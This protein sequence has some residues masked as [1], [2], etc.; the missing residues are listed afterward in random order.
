MNS[1]TSQ[2]IPVIRAARALESLRDSG[3][4]L[5][6]ALGEPTDNSIEAGAN[7]VHIRLDEG[8]NPRGK[9]H[10][11]RIAVADDGRGMN[12]DLLQHYLVL[13]FSTR[14]MR[15]DTIGKYG[16]GAKL[17][18]LNFACR[19][20]V[21]SRDRVTAPWLHVYFDLNKAIEEEK[22]GQEAKI[23]PP[24]QEPVPDDLRDLRPEGT[25]TLVVWSEM[26][27]LEE[28]RMAPT[29]EELRYEVE[30]EMSR[31]FRVFISGGIAIKVNGKALLAHDPLFLM[32]NTWA[33][34]VLQ[35]ELG[36]SGTKS[37]EDHFAAAIIANKETISIG[38]SIA[39]VTVTVYPPEVLRKRGLGG[40]ELVKKLRVPENQGCLS[41]MRLD[42]EVS[43]T[44]VPR[45]FPTAVDDPDRFI[46]IEVAFKPELDAYFGV[47]N[48]K[49]GVEP[50]GE[51][52]DK[53]RNL[54]SKHIKSARSMIQ[55]SWGKAARED[56]VNY[57]EH[58]PI[59]SVATDVNRVMPKGRAAGPASKE[60]EQRILE[61]LAADVVGRD[62]EVKQQE[63][64]EQ[65][66][67][68]P[69]VVESV[70]WP[71][72]M[73]I[74]V[75]HISN[76]VIIRLNTRHRFYRQMWEP[77]KDISQRAAGAVSGDEAV[78]AARRSIEALTLLF[79]A[80]G[81]AESMDPDPSQRYS[82]LTMFWGQFLDTLMTKVRDV[83]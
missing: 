44:N 28:G 37:G 23:Q 57:G 81:K 31:I 24:D 42:R 36:K 32:E 68:L 22:A 26:D 41:F 19:I 33:H 4:S 21:W 11:H 70:D 1:T 20:D 75:K 8:V 58:A 9:K 7:Y 47:R 80:Y 61:D 50:H 78:K 5:P 69:F 60:E 59:T 10:V 62:D 74:D 40:D 56:R 17:A 39:T 67:D 2:A 83:I 79:I 16:V 45:I 48:V 51:L 29:F 63:Y 15:K 13:G 46:G 25:G 30:K 66:K 55:E 12:D 82:E 6:T 72:N 35:K 54:L 76:K 43:Y 73:F 77:L 27:R 18:A 64:L 14:Y 49:R 3:H 52:R 34:S 53:L 71:G 65:I 38:G